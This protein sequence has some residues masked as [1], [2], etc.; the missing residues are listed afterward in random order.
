LNRFKRAIKEDE[1]CL[2]YQP[3]VELQEFSVVGLEALIRWNHPEH[4]LIYPNDFISLAEN[5]DLIVPL[6]NWVV[7]AAC[8]QLSAWRAQDLP[9]VAVA[10]NVS[11]RQLKDNELVETVKTTLAKYQIPPD[12]LEIEVTES[13]FIEDFDTANQVLEQ[14]QKSGIK[15]ALDD[16]GTGFS[17]L[18]NLKVLP[19]YAIKID[20]SFIRDIR[21]DNSDAVIVASTISLAHNLGLQ[22]VAEGV[23]SKEQL[24]HLKTAGCDQV[25]GFYFQRPVAASEMAALLQRGKFT[26]S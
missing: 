25:Q 11:S 23:E 4:G 14:L 6:G 15:I 12:L 2:H 9:L 19:I 10:I 24:V 26:P 20:R 22:V 13:C 7:D 1:F 3:R 16:Y 21:N 18:K 17:G 8:R 5:N